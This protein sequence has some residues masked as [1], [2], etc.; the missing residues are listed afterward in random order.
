M[1]SDRAS[2][3]APDAAL[4]PRAVDL[5]DGRQLVVRRLTDADT[6]RLRAL[7]DGLDDDDRRTRFFSVFPPGRSFVQRWLAAGHGVVLGA[8]VTRAT[9]TSVAAATET[10]ADADATAADGELVAE[11]GYALL[12]NGNGELGIT[13]AAGWRGW[14]GPYLLDLLVEV[15]HA[16][17]VP[18]IEADVRLDN[19]AMLGLIRHRGSAVVTPPA[20]GQVRLV[21]GTG[22]RVPG[23]PAR[24]SPLRARVL[25]ESPAGVWPPGAAGDLEVLGCPGPRDRPGRRCPLLEG[26][27]CPLVDGADAVIIVTDGDDT[28][29]A[30]VAGA[31]A[32]RTGAPQVARCGAAAAVGDLLGRIAAA[33]SARSADGDTRAGTGDP[34]APA[35]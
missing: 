14:L 9:A 16:E 30:A 32:A 34:A 23:W 5:G 17:G 11:A 7:Y 3:Q 1:P 31:H 35:G 18:N 25:V 15:A 20:G 19:P 28:Q 22:G 29:L 27:H 6:D 12:A 33:G 13:T 26:G 8:F 24:R 4:L 2:G 10:A 21:L